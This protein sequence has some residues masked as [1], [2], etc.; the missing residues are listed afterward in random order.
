MTERKNKPPVPPLKF[1]DWHLLESLAIV[2]ARCDYVA[3]RMLIA[4]GKNP[5]E[6]SQTDILSMSTR[7]SRRLKQRFGVTYVGYVEQ[8]REA[9]RVKL[10]SLQR[11]SAVNGNVTMQIWLGKQ[12]L[13]QVDKAENLN[14]NLSESKLVVEFT[15]EGG[16]EDGNED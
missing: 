4:S 11:T 5:F 12:E 2:E 1:F 10:R 16:D 13:G 3:E 15:K 8:K 7:I 14:K 9:W 6:I